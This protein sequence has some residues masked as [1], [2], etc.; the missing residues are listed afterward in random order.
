VGFGLRRSSA[1][2]LERRETRADGCLCSP[3]A[4]QQFWQDV[5]YSVAVERWNSIRRQ[6][7]FD[8]SLQIRGIVRSH[9]TEYEPGRTRI[10]HF[11]QLYRR[12]ARAARQTRAV[13]L[14][15]LPQIHFQRRVCDLEYPAFKLAETFSFGDSVGALE[16]GRQ[17][18]NLSN[19]FGN[20]IVAAFLNLAE[21]LVTDDLEA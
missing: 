20:I 19:T 1:S 5:R 11:L 3:I 16:F 2:I 8:G 18:P 15:D 10:A 21:T 12:P 4:R 7:L 13:L 9:V 6:G 17:K 14:K